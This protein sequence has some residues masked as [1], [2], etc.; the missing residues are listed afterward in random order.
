MRNY[1]PQSLGEKKSGWICGVMT[2]KYKAKTEGK[3]SL[4][5]GMSQDTIFNVEFGV[6]GMASASL[7]S[8]RHKAQSQRCHWSLNKL[9]PIIVRWWQVEVKSNSCLETD[10]KPQTAQWQSSTT[11]RL[12][13]CKSN[14]LSIAP[15]SYDSHFKKWLSIWLMNSDNI[16]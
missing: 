6:E 10:A 9:F 11:E 5:P 15:L 1:F 4:K 2:Q 12:L 7:N 13:L 14:V 8:H 16:H 3:K